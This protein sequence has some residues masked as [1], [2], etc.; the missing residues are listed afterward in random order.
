MTPLQR[1]REAEAK[2]AI[3]MA[4]ESAVTADAAMRLGMERVSKVWSGRI[5]G[6][7]LTAWQ[8]HKEF[9]A[10]GRAAVIVKMEKP[11]RL[12]VW[13]IPLPTKQRPKT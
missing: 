1:R 10:Q 12:S 2:A 5:W 3:T 6:N 7:R 13:A 11:Y 8:M 9:E 4:L